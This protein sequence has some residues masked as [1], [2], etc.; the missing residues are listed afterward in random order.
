[1]VTGPV[2]LGNPQEMTIE[3]IAREV[4][5]CTQSSSTLEFKPLPVD[6]P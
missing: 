5:T 1:M 6:D 3:A 4:P 2:N